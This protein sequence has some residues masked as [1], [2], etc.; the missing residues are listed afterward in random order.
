MSR[1]DWYRKRKR[2]LGTGTVDS[3]LPSVLDTQPVPRVTLRARVPLR[4]D[5]KPAVRLARRKGLRGAHA[6][7]HGSGQPVSKTV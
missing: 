4:W 1:R 2:E 6:A 7:H 3:C 5:N